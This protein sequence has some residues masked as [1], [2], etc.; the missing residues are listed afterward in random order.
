MRLLSFSD[1][2]ALGKSG[3]YFFRLEKARGK[4]CSAE[5]PL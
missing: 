5:N 4:G 1:V 3:L 2:P